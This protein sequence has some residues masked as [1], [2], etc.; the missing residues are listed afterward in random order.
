MSTRDEQ[1]T[2]LPIT[3]VT[4]LEDRAQV[5]RRGKVALAAGASRLTVK[6]VS[7]ILSDK[8]LTARTASTDAGL[9]VVDVRVVRRGALST[10][11]KSDLRSVLTREREQLDDEVAL[12]EA[13]KLADEEQLALLDALMVLTLDDLAADAAWGR[14]PGAEADVELD[15]LAEERSALR[16]RLVVARRGL[17][18]L[19]GRRARLSRRIAELEHPST[20]IEADLELD[21]E[22][23]EAGTFALEVD[24]VVPNAC[25]RPYHTAELRDGEVRFSTDG[26]V[27]QHTGEDWQGVDF[28]FS[29]ERASL[30]TEPPALTTDLV[31]VQRRA[32]ALE[33]EARD[34]MVKEASLGGARSEGLPGI[35][36]GGDPLAFRALAPAD[37]PSDGRPHRVPLAVF[38]APCSR[39]L[40]CYPEL[41]LAVLL[42]TEQK[43]DANKPILAGP[44][45]LIRDSGLAGRTAVLFVGPGERFALGWGPE[46]ELRAQRDVDDKR[47]EAGML[48]SWEETSHNVVVRLSN[49]GDATR[50]VH[51]RE[52][53]PVSEIEKVK[54]EPDPR[55]TTDEVSPDEDG[56][57]DWEVTVAPHERREIVLRYRV[58]KHSDVVG[59]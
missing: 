38:T 52:R 23:A 5:A 53:V 43:N 57:V 56:F 20:L 13:E 1:T 35:D 54:I 19:V 14:A 6:A 22:A 44:V 55:R 31:R 27:W 12:A 16:E 25:W 11:H 36:D 32:P 37:V 24:Y 2:L 8:S 30:G 4:L 17:E 10:D 45:D 3:R 33:V 46:A 40:V 48:S 21:V 49:L 39:E 47:D 51:L 9:R 42:R 41:E 34:T 26:C 59:L 7:P 18:E 28:V 50:V 15:Q 29:T 58:K